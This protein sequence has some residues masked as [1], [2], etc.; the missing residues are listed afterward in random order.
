MYPYL[1]AL[2]H[3]MEVAVDAA[4]WA[5]QADAIRTQLKNPNGRAIMAA[6]AGVA[7]AYQPI[8]VDAPIVR[9]Q[10]HNLLA[11]KFEELLEDQ[12]YKEL[13]AENRFFGIPALA[14]GAKLKVGRAV[15]AFINRPKAQQLLD[16]G[17]RIVSAATEVPVPESQT[18]ARLLER[19]FLPPLICLDDL[20]E[21]AEVAWKA[22]RPEFVP[23]PGYTYRVA[24]TKWDDRGK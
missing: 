23:L 1:L 18:V 19:N 16:S 20:V 3:E 15:K 7:R 22:A 6:I 14:Q 8:T 11:E 4:K 17:T 5:E 21:R 12:A 13:S 24:P 9:P 2:E 10:A